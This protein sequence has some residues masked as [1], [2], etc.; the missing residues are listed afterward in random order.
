RPHRPALEPER[1]S[2][3]L[4]AEVSAGRLDSDAVEAVLRAAGH[5]ASA[6]QARPS[7]LT[8]R[9]VE[10][11]RLLARG[12][13][14]KQIAQQLV[15]APKTVANHVEH[16]YLKIGVS[17]RAAATLYATQHGLMGA[18]ESAE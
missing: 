2:R 17:S 13:S 11:L 1:A 5:R 4:R 7:G 9:E 18:F 3:E 6:R 8:S 14:N 16:I 10:V 12:G 15:V